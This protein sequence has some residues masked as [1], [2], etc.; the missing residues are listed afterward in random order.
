LDGRQVR[1]HG[2]T[3]T[4]TELIKRI[5]RRTNTHTLSGIRTQ[6]PSVR[7]VEDNMRLER[8]GHCDK[9]CILDKLL[10]CSNVSEMGF[11]LRLLVEPTQLSPIDR[12]SPYVQTPE[13][14]SYVTTDGQSDS[15][16]WNKAA[17]WGLRPDP[18]YCQDTCGFVGVGR[19]L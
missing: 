9:H 17:I 1:V 2:K 13:P 10:L 8:H 7:V 18:Y 3:S 11:C 15:L 4:H 16:S 6:H 14:E 12:A 5:K 19:S